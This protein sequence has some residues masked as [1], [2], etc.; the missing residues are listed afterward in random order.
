[1]TLL[2]LLFE[3]QV[4]ILSSR[5]SKL[6]CST[7][8]QRTFDRSDKPGIIGAR[9]TSDSLATWPDRAFAPCIAQAQHGPTHWSRTVNCVQSRAAS[10][11]SIALLGDGV[12]YCLLRQRS[13]F[14]AKEPAPALATASS[15]LFPWPRR[16]S[17]SPTRPPNRASL[18]SSPVPDGF[19]EAHYYGLGIAAF[20]AGYAPQRKDLGFPPKKWC[21]G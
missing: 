5:P 15:F 6:A 3:S 16:L 17:R 4:Q 19:W 18:I 1:M 11:L 21:P 9:F 10:A 20:C 8:V 14:P 2:L 7:C 12:P 13:S